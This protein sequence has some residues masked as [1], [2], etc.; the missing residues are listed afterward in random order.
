MFIVP[1]AGLFFQC[2]LLKQILDFQQLDLVHLQDA[3]EGK[4]GAVGGD[5]V[6]GLVRHRHRHSASRLPALWLTN[7]FF[8]RYCPGRVFSIWK[9]RV[10]GEEWNRPSTF[11]LEMLSPYW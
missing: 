11:S 4:G 10:T 8:T 9:E 5:G 2:G 6:V 1:Y 7:R 3:G